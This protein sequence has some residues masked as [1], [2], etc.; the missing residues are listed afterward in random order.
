MYFP[1]YF[2]RFIMLLFCLIS[3]FRCI[4]YYNRITGIRFYEVIIQMLVSIFNYPWTCL[5]FA[6]MVFFFSYTVCMDVVNY[7]NYAKMKSLTV[8]T[9][10]THQLHSFIISFRCLL[11]FNEKFPLLCGCC[12]CV[13]LGHS[14]HLMLLCF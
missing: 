2:R 13:F 1:S 14:T 6:L 5:L 9:S 3:F 4:V 10:L 7:E 12:V 11:L 8:C